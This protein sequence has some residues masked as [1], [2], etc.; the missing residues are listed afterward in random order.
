MCGL[1][2]RSVLS[3]RNGVND[4]FSME[5]KIMVLCLAAVVGF[6]TCFVLSWFFRDKIKAEQQVFDK[7]KYVKGHRDVFGMR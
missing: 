2:R 5:Y 6:M 4:M 1:K 7:Q 3:G